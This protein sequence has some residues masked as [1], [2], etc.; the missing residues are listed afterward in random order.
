MAEWSNDMF[1]LSKS[2]VHQ[3][4]AWPHVQSHLCRLTELLVHMGVGMWMS[5]LLMV[6]HQ[7]PF[8]KL[9]KLQVPSSLRWYHS[10]KPSYLKCGTTD[11]FQAAFHTSRFL[12]T[13]LW[14]FKGTCICWDA[15]CKDK[16]G[17]EGWCRRWNWKV[18][19]SRLILHVFSVPS[20]DMN[21]RNSCFVLG[22]IKMHRFTTYASAST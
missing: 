7:R 13:G 11:K 20:L 14:Y 21:L 6:T 12:V 10:L 15:L 5:Q 22:L 3:V 8:V 19:F 4:L 2:T 17:S 9:S 1:V 18:R 16:C